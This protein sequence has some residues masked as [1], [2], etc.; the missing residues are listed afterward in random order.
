MNELF[1]FHNPQ[2]LL[3]FFLGHLLGNI[4]YIH[5]IPIIYNNNNSNISSVILLHDA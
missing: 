3:T 5:N 1:P 4:Y 2:G